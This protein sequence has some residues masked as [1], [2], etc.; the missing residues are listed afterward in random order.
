MNTN[1]SVPI[2]V[3]GVGSIGSRHLRNLQYLGYTNLS[4][5]DSDKKNLDRARNDF[6]V[7]GNSDWREAL[8]ATKPEVTFVCVPAHLHIPIALQALAHDSHVFI[9]KPLSSRLHR[10]SELM[11][12]SRAKKKLV[13]IACNYRFHQGFVSLQITGVATQVPVALHLSPVVQ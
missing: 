6:R 1:L 9:E 2:L 5:A 12:I 13:M 4:V 10:V 8:N 11:R 3:I 7:L